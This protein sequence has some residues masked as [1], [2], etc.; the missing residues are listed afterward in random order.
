MRAEISILRI[1]KFVSRFFIN[2]YKKQS[3]DF[4]KIVGILG[5]CRIFSVQNENNPYNFQKSVK[6]LET[7]RKSVQSCHPPYGR[8]PFLWQTCVQ[9]WAWK[10]NFRK[11]RQSDQPTYRPMNFR[12]HKEVTVSKRLLNYL[13]LLELLLL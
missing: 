7:V 2:P 10:C 8:I 3:T 5:C 12:G 13:P 11:L 6:K 9:I 4:W 1:E